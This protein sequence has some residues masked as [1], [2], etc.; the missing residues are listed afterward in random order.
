MIADLYGG[1][2]AIAFALIAFGVAQI[3]ATIGAGFR[4]RN[5]AIDRDDKLL[6][7][8]PDP[9]HI[10]SE[11]YLIIPALNEERVIGPTVK[12]ALKSSD[13]VNVIVVDDGSDDETASIVMEIESPRVHLLGRTFPNAR[14]GKGEALNYA[15]RYLRAVV[16]RRA[17]DPSNVLVCIMDADGRLSPRAIPWVQRLFSDPMVGGAQLPV[18]IR[19]TGSLLTD[20]QDFEFWG[21]SAIQQLA[22]G[23]THTVSLGGNGQFTRLEALICLE[24]QPWTSSLTEDLD[25]A[26]S[27]LADGWRIESTANAFVSQQAVNEVRPLIRQ[28]VRWMQ[29]HLLSAGRL[30]EIHSSG[31]RRAAVLEITNYLMVPLLMILPWSLIFNVS[32]LTTWAHF[33]DIPKVALF[34]VSGLGTGAIFAF[35]A[36]S[37]FFPHLMAGLIYRSRRPQLSRTRALGLGVG[38]TLY[39]YVTFVATWTAI[40]RILRGEHG[41]T[42]TARSVEVSPA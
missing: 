11:V 21:L 30:R 24:N 2:G 41:W 8:F 26:V 33:S 15:F 32:L 34:G 40:W 31:L 39:N 38:F 4:E 36:V 18:R 23:N 1:I 12:A 25:L 22:R 9:N 37:S 42:K 10:I 16:N 20:Y 6:A 35:L 17:L 14:Q 29:G 27:L 5:R 3:G 13:V 19:N 28:R 7:E